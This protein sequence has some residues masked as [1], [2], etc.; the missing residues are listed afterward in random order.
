MIMNQH[1]LESGKV[2][3]AFVS[4]LACCSVDANSTCLSTPSLALPGSK[5]SRNGNEII[6]SSNSKSGTAVHTSLSSSSSSSS[7]AAKEVVCPGADQLPC[8]LE[9]SGAGCKVSTFSL[10]CLDL[11][12]HKNKFS[13]LPPTSTCTSE[14]DISA[15]NLFRPVRYNKL[16]ISHAS[17]TAHKNFCSTFRSLVDERLRR[18][19]LTLLQR[20]VLLSKTEGMDEL[21]AKAY[22]CTIRSLLPSKSGE[23]NQ[24]IQITASVTNW[25]TSPP[26]EGCTTATSATT[27][28]TAAGKASIS[29]PVFFEAVLDVAIFGSGS[30]IE[31]SNVSD[32]N[33]SKITLRFSVPGT[34]SAVFS[35]FSSRIET[36]Q[37][38]LSSVELV[39]ALDAKCQEVVHKVVEMSRS[40]I[41]HIL[42]QNDAV[43][44]SSSAPTAGTITAEQEPPQVK[45]A[46]NST[47]SS[48]S[49]DD[50]DV[51]IHKVDLDRKMMPP[52]PPRPPT[53]RITPALHQSKP[54]R[55]KSH[56]FSCPGEGAGHHL[57]KHARLGSSADNLHAAITA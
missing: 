22:S 50:T 3:H 27:T 23:H 57:A 29:Q 43:A 40:R 30:A 17:A 52:P 14:H 32:G 18:A 11:V 49:T 24:P 53:V 38:Q 21:T 46:R 48:R 7:G 31:T 9:T 44:T 39:K 42:E 37:I 10:P 12:E 36:I 26:Q 56:S 5:R 28:N 34:V 6:R 45:S 8:F 51:K 19:A 33:A 55:A 41:A 15:E 54:K 35:R 13:T 16:D 20:S 25:V 4:R 2:L 1:Q 47:F